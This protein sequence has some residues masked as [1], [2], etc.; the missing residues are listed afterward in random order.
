MSDRA[1]LVRRARWLVGFTA[2]Y[3]VAEAVASIASGVV[4]LSVALIGFGLDS[5]IEVSAAVILLWR[6]RRDHL[7]EETEHRAL[8]AIGVTF[9]L[10]AAFVVAQAS[11]TLYIRTEPEPSLPGIVIAV[12]S[13]SL[14]PPLAV[15][16]RRIGKQIGSAAMEA[17]SM[18]T[19]VCSILSATLLVG[20]GANWAFGWWW[21]DPAAALAMVPFLLYEGWEAWEESAEASPG[22]S[23]PG[24]GS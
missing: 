19:V 14:M 17:E 24:A 13:L 16:K 8:R 15:M 2:A 1:S 22:E 21:A 6:L 9:L 12:L 18:E 3:N 23:A 4:A 11:W 7:R 5:G 10:L 20:L